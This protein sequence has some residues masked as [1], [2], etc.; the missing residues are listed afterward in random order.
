MDRVFTVRELL[1]LLTEQD[2]KAE[3]VT[4]GADA[5][6]RDLEI[7]GQGAD[8]LAFRIKKNSVIE[9]IGKASP[10]AHGKAI[11]DIAG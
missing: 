5:T 6:R 10:L 8:G 1:E 3:L 11:L 2:P 7:Y 4:L 9:P